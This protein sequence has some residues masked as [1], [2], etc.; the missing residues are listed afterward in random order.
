MERRPDDAGFKTRRLHD[1]NMPG[2]RSIL[3]VS[4]LAVA[5]LFMAP[6]QRPALT[7]QWVDAGNGLK[8]MQHEVTIAQWRECFSE[9]ACTFMP[10]PGLGAVDDSY[11]VTGIGA[12][13]AQEFVAWAQKRSGLPVQLPS[14]EQ[15]YA[16]SETPIAATTKLFTDPRMAW[17]A[18]YGSEGKTDPKLKPP[19]SFG[20]TSK[21]IADVKG[22]VWEWT[23]SCVQDAPADRCPAWFAAGDHLAKVPV[24]VRDPT[25]GGC[26]TGTPPAHLGMRLVIA[27][28]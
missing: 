17:A 14:V 7:L 24:F 21:N 28:P 10:K 22:N 16:F 4:V 11:P 19:G 20:H 6:Q 27:T 2:A 8:V 3:L 23:R 25:T 5:A 15:W 13:D 26:A 1:V 12:L 9:G 18:T